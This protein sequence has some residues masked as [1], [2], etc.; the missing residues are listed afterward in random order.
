[1]CDIHIGLYGYWNVERPL[2]EANVMILA[3]NGR[4][5]Y[6]QQHFGYFRLFPLYS[7]ICLPNRAQGTIV[8]PMFSCAFIKSLSTVYYVA[9]ITLF[10]IDILLNWFLLLI[11]IVVCDDRLCGASAANEYLNGLGYTLLQYTQFLIDFFSTVAANANT[12]TND[13]CCSKDCKIWSKMVDRMNYCVY[14]FTSIYLINKLILI[15]LHTFALFQ[16]DQR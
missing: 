4:A 7:I 5:T 16:I 10:S 12:W 3:L 1:M 13:L 8:W 15:V 6:F 11:S 2:L 14:L 9:Y